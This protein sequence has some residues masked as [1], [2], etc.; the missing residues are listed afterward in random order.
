MEQINR[1]F[2]NNLYN[3][4]TCWAHFGSPMWYWECLL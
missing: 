2:T 1:D 4:K 3:F